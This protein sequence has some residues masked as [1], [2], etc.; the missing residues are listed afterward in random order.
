[1]RLNDGK[2]ADEGKGSTMW[3][4]LKKNDKS[5]EKFGKVGGG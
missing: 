1:M 4:S 3:W 2:H 5:A